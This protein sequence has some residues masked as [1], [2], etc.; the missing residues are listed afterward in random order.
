MLIKIDDDKWDIIMEALMM[1]INSSMIEPEIRKELEEAVEAIDAH[2]D[3]NEM[4]SRLWAQLEATINWT[5]IIPE[6]GPN[7][8]DL[9]CLICDSLEGDCECED[10]HR[11]IPPGEYDLNGI[12]ELLRDHKENPEAI[13]YIADMMEN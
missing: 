5:V 10:G 9:Y 12:V 6:E 1:D 3:A 2:G 11:T 8:E 4:H 13:Q 7:N